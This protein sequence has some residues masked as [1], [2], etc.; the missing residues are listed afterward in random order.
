MELFI[1]LFLI[2]LN[3]VLAMSELAIVSAKP[4]RLKAKADEGSKGARA[5]LKLLDDPSRM[6]STIQVGITLIGI[7]AGAYGATAIADDIAPFVAET[8]PALAQWAGAISFGVVIAF[9]TYLSLVFGEL[10][11]KRL[12]LI[13]PESV[14]SV[15]APGLSALSTAFSPVVSLLKTSMDGVLRLM[16][17]HKISVQPVTEEEIRALIEQGH[18]AG[19]IE[20]EEREMITGVMRL[21]DRTVRA[22]MTPRPELVWLD[23]RRSWA[24]NA[25]LIRESGHARFPVAESTIDNVIGV[26][27]TKDLVTAGGPEIDLRKVMHAPV[28]VPDGLSVLRVLKTMRKHPVRMLF[29]TDEYGVIEGIVT[30][31]DIL[32]AIAGDVALSAEEAIDPPVERADGSWLIDGMTPIDEFERLFDVTGLSEGARFDTVAGLVLD[33]LRRLPKEGDTADKWPLSFEV[34]DM[35][36]RRIDKLVVRR[37]EERP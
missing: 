14:A 1:L 8:A 3:G 9:T 33:L 17:A 29:V 34:V 7:V 2:L 18:Y 13:A 22:V 15:V 28:F 36:R 32:E 20:P 4:P 10:V 25:A 35:D 12:A 11:P 19:L 37:M 31:A 26:V 30:D 21:G 23:P 16:G 24:E 27:Q 5:A 6:L